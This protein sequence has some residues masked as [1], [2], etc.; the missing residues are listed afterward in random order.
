MFGACKGCAARSSL[1]NSHTKMCDF[2][3]LTCTASDR[4]DDEVLS[5]LIYSKGQNVGKI[6][7]PLKSQ[8][9]SE[10]TILVYSYISKSPRP[11]GGL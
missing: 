2:H 7:T 6:Y 11:L 5:L 3:K 4:A 10:E 9:V 1:G 8:N